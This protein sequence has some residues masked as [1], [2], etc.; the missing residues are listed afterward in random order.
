MTC[1]IV[2]GILGI[3]M[4]AN[5]TAAAQPNM[6]RM[7]RARALADGLVAVLE[8]TPTFLP[9][10]GCLA[11]PVQL[12]WQETE[13]KIGR[14]VWDWSADNLHFAMNTRA[15]LRHGLVG[16]AAEAAVGAERA[17]GIEE[18]AYLG[19]IAQCHRA[20]AAFV[21]RHAVEAEKR[22]A[23][24]GGSERSRLAQMADVCRAVSQRAP[25]TFLEAVQLVWFARCIRRHGTI[26]RLDQHLYPF[27]RADV[28]EGRLAREDALAILV[29]LWECFNLVSPAGDSLQNMI[30][31]G[32]LA[33]GTDATNEV[34]GLMIEATLAVPKSEPYV[35]VRLHAGTPDWFQDRVAELQCKGQGK[36]AI[37]NDDRLIPALVGAGVPLEQAR[38]YAN[39]GCTEV[40]IDGESGLTLVLGEVL[41]C[42]ELALFNGAENLPGQPKGKYFLRATEARDLH[43][44]VQLGLQTGDF[45]EMT[46]YEQVYDAFLAQF[47]RHVDRM[48]DQVDDGIRNEREHGVSHPFLAGTFP[49][50]LE[51]GKDLYRG[52]F[53][54]PCH[55][56]FPGSI[57]V[58]ADA[59]AAL[60]EVVFEERFCTPPEMLAALRADFGGHEALR[61]RC[62]AAPKFGNDEDYVDLIA[63][64]IADR[65]C[66]R[67][68][69]RPNRTGKPFWPTLFNHVFNDHAKMVG[70]TP[71]GRRWGDP[72]GEHFSP[73]PGRAGKGPT[74]IVRSVVKAPL[75]KAFGS[76]VFNISMSRDEMPLGAT[77]RARVRQ[78]VD[79]ALR[80]GVVVMS[81]AVYSVEELEH[82]RVH[83]E[84][85][86]DLLVRV[87]GFS[88]RF[89]DLAE[90]MQDHIIQRVTEDVELQT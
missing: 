45:A 64:D 54:V 15:L 55:T 38:N 6:D 32:V 43:T 23:L 50:S 41:K 70:A 88:A 40:T 83:P 35:S 57:P 82:A 31:G 58:V 79:A 78:F 76:P 75:H 85:H 48:L 87:W 8:N 10:T 60:K 73:V 47:L 72:I 39:D 65:F 18:A 20:A 28:D 2:L 1:P 34:S 74:A 17:A 51:T 36:G 3:V 81:I 44:S 68:T 89:V 49:V 14:G 7:Q 80:Q 22:A 69:A 12:E 27:Y 37:Y 42:L 16:I 19:A 63:A 13:K 86:Q 61:Q 56:V 4:N 5:E 52:G 84:Q 33:D 24:D 59:L 25:R 67:V 9:E 26:G 77:G 29:D 53:T 11:G 90:D 46:S 30:V 21:G 71:D 62:L 66:D